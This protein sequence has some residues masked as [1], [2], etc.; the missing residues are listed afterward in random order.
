MRP[1]LSRVDISAR[2]GRSEPRL[3]VRNLSTTLLR[4]K[5]RHAAGGPVVRET[6]EKTDCRFMFAVLFKKAE[7]AHKEFSPMY[8]K[9]QCSNA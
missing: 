9:S 4:C 7:G 1:P 3:S 8:Y 5:R 6:E 2:N